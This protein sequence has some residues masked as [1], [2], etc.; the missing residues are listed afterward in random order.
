MNVLN[1][2]KDSCAI[3]KVSIVLIDWSCR[4]S[5]HI[6][7]YLQKQT[8]PREEYEIIWVEY[9]NRKFIKI[10]SML[11]ECKNSNKPPV[12]DKWII[13]DMHDNIYYHKHLMYNIGIIASKGEI[14]TICDSDAIVTPTFVESIIDAFEKD[15][16]IVL[17]IDEVRNFNKKFYPF[18]YPSVQK[19]ISEG[20]VNFKNGKTT[21]LLDADDPLHTRNYGACVCAFR[22]DI[23]DIGGADEHVDYLGY[24]CGPYELAFRLV[25]AGKKEV[26]HQEELLYHAW[27]PGS[28]GVNDYMG[29]HDGYNMSAP[30]L[31][32]KY[33]RRIMPL[34]ENPVIQLIRLNKNNGTNEEALFSRAINEDKAKDWVIDEKKHLIFLG[35][36]AHYKGE[37][38]EALKSW[39]KVLQ[40]FPYEKSFLNEMAWAYYYKGRYKEALSFFNR[41]ANIDKANQNVIKGLAWVNFKMD[42]F[43]SAIDNFN[44]LL[45]GAQCLNKNFLQENMRALGWAYLK[46]GNLDQA[47]DTFKKIIN[48]KY[49]D[50]KIV[51]QDIF[52]GLGWAYYHKG[53]Y[54]NALDN[55]KLALKNIDQEN[56]EL[57]NN[58]QKGLSS[59]YQ[60]KDAINEFGGI[61]NL[62]IRSGLSY[63]YFRLKI[64]SIIRKIKRILKKI[65][66]KYCRI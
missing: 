58:I 54:T 63:L 62:K 31:D 17:Y 4:E 10:E 29:P 12:I 53:D 30:A 2:K 24:I 16:N 26:W 48:N 14:V 35:R 64:I 37:Y 19:L 47:V 51:L 25:N 39:N 23:I 45:Q 38:D 32:A 34:V 3:P 28:V 6:L 21:G 66:K 20:A 65:Y 44:K 36:L 40:D 13:L 55:F 22:Q 27:H 56:K 9:Y 59:I 43:N 49:T 8:I 5:P 18:N 60:K 15:R 11:D 33:S 46:N 57:V 50:E 42:N 41:A 7:D 61:L 52:H 1:F